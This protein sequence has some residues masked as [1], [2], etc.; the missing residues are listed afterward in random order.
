[1][2]P[3]VRHQVGLK[4]IQV[5]IKGTIETKRGGD[6]RNNLADQTIEIS[7]RRPLNVQVTTANIIDGLHHGIN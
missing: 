7:V 5:H 1:M 6:R 3:W 4:F 2:N